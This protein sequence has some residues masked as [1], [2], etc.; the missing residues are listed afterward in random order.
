MSTNYLI[1]VSE[2]D[3]LERIRQKLLTQRRKNEREIA[4]A[5]VDNGKRRN[6]LPKAIK[7]NSKNKD[8]LKVITTR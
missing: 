4:H 8:A 1:R 7:N 5:G 6:S 2:P 3:R